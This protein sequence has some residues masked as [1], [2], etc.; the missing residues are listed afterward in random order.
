M[1]PRLLIGGA[2]GLFGLAVF[3]TVALPYVQTNDLP[4][5]E[6]TYRYSEKAL[7]GRA[8]YVRE[9]CWY[10]HTQQVRPWK[11]V[12]GR[13][14]G[15]AA[16]ADLGRPSDPRDFAN[17]RPHVLGTERTGPDLAHVGSRQSSKEWHIKHLKDPREVS[18]GSIMPSFAYLSDEELDD[19]ADYLMALE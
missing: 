17:D 5:W 16:D 3:F 6:H 13:I 8:I 2:L 18:D 9:G 10:C 4:A 1:T 11:V 14:E 19:L 12:D 15:V 7:R